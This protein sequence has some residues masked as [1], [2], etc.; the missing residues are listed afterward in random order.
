MIELGEEFMRLCEILLVLFVVVVWG[1]NFVIIEVGFGMMLLFFLVV[2]CFVVVVF[3]VIFILC[4]VVLW[5]WFIFIGFVF[6][7]G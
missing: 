7:I 5:F 4:F 6:F 3:L 1:V 2:F